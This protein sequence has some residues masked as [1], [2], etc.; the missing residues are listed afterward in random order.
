MG[1]VFVL[2][3][4][5]GVAIEPWLRSRGFDLFW[6]DTDWLAATLAIA[7]GLLVLAIRRRL[8]AATGLILAMAA[9]WWAGFAILVLGLDLHM[10][11]P[12]GDNWAGC[13][14]MTLAALVV[15]A[16]GPGSARSPAPGWSAASSAGSASPRRRCS[17]WSR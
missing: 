13:L 1:V 10:T 15:S 2:W 6:Y 12:R 4:L 17:S 8:D 9:G 16:D 14:G 3:W 5:Q 7:G 11:P